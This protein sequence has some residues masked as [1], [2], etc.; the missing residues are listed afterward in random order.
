MPDS[1]SLIGQ[2]ILHYRI[3]EKLGGGGMGVVYRAE[4]TRLHRNVALKFLPDDV[5]R[6]PQALARFERE[7]QA[8]S[9]LNHPNI[10]TVH[11]IGEENG[12]AFI[13]MECLEG[14]TL[15]QL[16]RDQPMEL[17]RLLDL[18]VEIADALDAA[19]S[20]GIVHRDIK[21]ANIF[22]T[23]RGH[24]KILDF[25][26]A[27]V[28][29]PKT[30]HHEEPTRSAHDEV[31]EH[32]T[33]PGTALGTIAYMSPEQARGQELGARSDLFSLGAVL[34]ELATHQ[35]AFAGDTS[36]VVFDAIL[37]REPVPVTK[38]QRHLPLKLEEI[39]AKL[40]EK[41]CD[42]RY[43][44]A[45]E[46]R[47]DLKRLKRDLG[48]PV[49]SAERDSGSGRVAARSSASSPAVTPRP[50]KAGKTIDSLAVLPFE[51]ASG[52]P[53]NE[54]L[55][56][57]LTETIINDLSRLPKMRVV[58]RG[59]VFRYK[60]KGVDA[61]TAAT[62][63]GVRAVVSGRVLQHKDTLIVKAEL[64]DVLRQDQLW[65][66]SYNRKMADLLEVQEE[67]ARE[68][69][70]RLQ[71]RLGGQPAPVA[72]KRSTVNPEAYRLYLQGAHQ[73]QLWTEEGLRNSL[74]L[75]QQAIALD[76]GHAPSFAVLAY[77]LT[78]MGFYGF[79]RGTE[80]WPKA[81]AIAN[82]AIQL[83]PTVA[84]A[85]VAL[86]LHALQAERNLAR[87]IS[88]A[89]EAVRLKPDLAIAHHGLA[90]ALNSARRSEEALAAVRKAA[91]LDPLTPLFQAHVAWILHCLGRHDEA[92]EQLKSTLAVHP[93]DY[94]VLRILV[95]CTNTPERCK[96]AI[97]AWER[98]SNLDRSKYVAQGILGTIY[99]RA[100]ERDRALAI[101][102]QLEEQL[103]SEPSLTYFL[104]LVR[105]ELGEHEVAIQWLEKAEELRLGI[106]IILSCEPSFNRLRPFP[107][108]QALLRKLG[109]PSE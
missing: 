88:E 51:N 101:A 42:F 4:D 35:Q 62:E 24:A 102:S 87:G 54:Y 66:D 55:S 82:K 89:Q 63:L 61:F 72:V 67:I 70:A 68:I 99:A 15:R 43:Q 48:A 20:K 92:W 16:N 91:E 107:R 80:A 100:G 83:D 71:Q 109:L 21:P 10:C 81:K 104:A 6:D 11:D 57:G 73:A 103:S 3:I 76:P 96:V 44:S 34:Y 33:S 69:A 52:D 8:A 108:F 32:L 9:A 74:E 79:I 36:A 50:P 37:N 38:L 90:I 7:A 93:N 58:P 53:D 84:E 78:M 31:P 26:L 23:A 106:L 65:G 64:V 13:A 14:Q 77:S 98:I 1:R 40:L 28:A 41:D 30:A 12:R 56:D 95:Y 59:V 105:C 60:G 45:S 39:I 2:T 17:Q 49:A 25:G 97:E 86:S 75:F 85:H 5:A 27:K 22:V 46:V 47:A 18:A 29:P 94:Y 19:H